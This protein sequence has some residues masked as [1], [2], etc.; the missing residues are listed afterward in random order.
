[1]S[2]KTIIIIGALILSK[3]CANQLQ[4]GQ[5]SESYSLND[6]ELKYF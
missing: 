6:K 3:V 2:L 1:M 4:I 5:I